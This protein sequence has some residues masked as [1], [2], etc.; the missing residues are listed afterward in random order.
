[1]IAT[2]ILIAA[3]CLLMLAATCT[4]AAVHGWQDGPD[5]RSDRH[6]WLPRAFY[7]AG[8]RLRRARM[9]VARAELEQRR[10]DT[11]AFY[12]ALDAAVKAELHQKDHQ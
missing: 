9:D 8:W 3:V 5:N 1:V 6:Q 7:E 12:A 11:E 10:A 2:S 4:L